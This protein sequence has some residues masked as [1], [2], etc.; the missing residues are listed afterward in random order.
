[1]LAEVSTEPFCTNTVSLPDPVVSFSIRGQPV[2]DTM[3]KDMLLSLGA[4]LQKDM[5][6]CIQQTRLELQDLG[7]RVDHVDFND[8]YNTLVDAHTAQSEDISW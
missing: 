6:S 4:S 3:M 5:M 2:S 8:N 7:D 1:M